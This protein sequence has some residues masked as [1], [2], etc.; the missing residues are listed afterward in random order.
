MAVSSSGGLI[1]SKALL[2]SYNPE[3][4]IFFTST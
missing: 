2:K 1:T 3:L 4:H